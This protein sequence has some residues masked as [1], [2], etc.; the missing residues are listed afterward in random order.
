MRTSNALVL[1]LHG[2]VILSCLILGGCSNS[3]S[4]ISDTG[5]KPVEI[6][7][8]ESNINR[9]LVWVKPCKSTLPK[10]NTR[11]GQYLLLVRKNGEGYYER[12]LDAQEIEGGV[13]K[14]LAIPYSDTISKWTVAVECVQDS[15]TKATILLSNTIAIDPTNPNKNA[16]ARP[17]R[18]RSV[19]NISI[20]IDEEN[21][22]IDGEIVPGFQGLEV[23]ERI[24]GKPSRKVE[25]F[26]VWDEYGISVKGSEAS[27]KSLKLFINSTDYRVLSDPNA[28]F[29]GTIKSD[30][31]TL[32]ATTKLTD[33][34]D[35][36]ITRDTTT[37]WSSN[38]ISV[39]FNKDGQP[40]ITWIEF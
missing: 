14:D 17:A 39:Q 18:E 9:P 27:L 26:I 8:L 19:R 6:V 23:L 25:E 16:V 11:F 4:S 3:S 10:S 34:P 30:N 40:T 12:T 21:I 2:Y 1:G 33:L 37:Q 35:S 22:K 20:V 13:E 15:Q 7:L 32:L 31:V 28:L 29:G 36:Q 24:L 38:R 5:D